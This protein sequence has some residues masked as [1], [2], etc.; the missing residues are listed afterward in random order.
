VLRSYL[1]VPG[2]RPDRFD[3]ACAT[4]AGAV[5]VDL[6]DAVAPADKAGARDA[7]VAWLSAS[8][9]VVVRVNA[10]GSEWFDDDLRACANAGVAAVVLPK[11]EGGEQIERVTATCARPVLPLVETA[12]GMWSVLDIARARGVQRLLF[13]SL[14]YQVDLG[15]TDDDLLLAR[16]QLVLASRVAGIAA[17]IDGITQ[18]IDDPELLRRDCERARRLGFGGK[19]CIH[20]RQVEIVN[21]CFAPS[22]DDVAWATR[23]V[24]AFAASA[25]N[26]TLLDGKMIDGPVLT[27]AQAILDEAASHRP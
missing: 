21:H 5:I 7:L 10:A 13:G 19:L 6:E 27:Q 23:V 3:K 25:G 17:P 9:P 11:A 4:R 14:D 26:A 20:P 15:T 2:N 1:F 16:S 18:A 24:D 22:D 8:R 12:R